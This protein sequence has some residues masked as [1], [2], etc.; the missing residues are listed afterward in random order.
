[1]QSG[2]ENSVKIVKDVDSTYNWRRADRVNFS[3][4]EFLA[5]YHS[6]PTSEAVPSRKDRE[7]N[8]SP[9]VMNLIIS[10]K[11]PA[12]VRAWWLEAETQREAEW[13]IV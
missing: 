9:D 4:L 10:L 2:R 1:M 11:K 12:E 7:M 13:E 3:A 5:I 8:Y 6:H